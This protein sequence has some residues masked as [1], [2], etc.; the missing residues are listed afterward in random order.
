MR[1]NRLAFS[2]IW[3]AAALSVAPCL[4]ED[5]PK[6]ETI[7]DKYVE[8]TGG[9]DAYAKIHGDISSGAMSFGAMGITG[10]MVSYTQAPDKRLV[11]VTIEGIG[12]ISDGSNGEVA[13][14]LSAMQGPHLKEGDEKAEAMLQAKH[15]ADAQWRE[16][17]KS[18]ETVGV[19]NVDGKD[20]YKLVLTPNTGKPMTRWF[21]KQTYLAAKFVV[22]SKSPMGEIQIE[23]TVGD[24]RKEGDILMPHKV[25]SHVAGQELTMTIDKVEYNP[26]IPKDKFDPPAEIKALMK[27]AA[28]K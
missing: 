18:V 25:V 3:F 14:S 7:L 4:A 16:L 26:D 13:W 19:E 12:K 24:Y 8:V 2:V 15:N 21:D 10:K 17:Y 27:P 1:N 5:L 28:K 20:C 23:S 22:T 11:E 9:K 6:A